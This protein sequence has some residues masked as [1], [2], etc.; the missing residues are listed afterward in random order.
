MLSRIAGAIR[1]SHVS[2]SERS[3][4]SRISAA[5]LAI[6][7]FTVGVKVVALGSTLLIA[8]FFGTGDDL[9]AFL[10]AFLLPSM[11]MSVI[12]GAFRSALIPTYVQVRE[13]YGSLHAQS[14]F[15]RIMFVAS[16]IL[17][18]SVGCFAV[19]VPY[20]LPLLASGF[21]PTKLAL[22]I[23]LSYLL[24]PV[25][26][27]KGIAT[28]YGA[29]LNAEERFSLVAAAPALIPATT[30]LF[31]LLWPVPATRIYGLAVATIVGMVGE[32]I[33]V[34][35]ALKLRGIALLPRRAASSAASRQVISQY[36]PIL[37][38]A[39][40]MS[41]TAFVDE[42]MAASLSAGSLASLSYGGRFVNVILQVLSGAIA[43]AV[44]PFFSKLVDERNWSALRSLLRVYIARILVVTAGITLLLVVSSETL[45]GLVL[46]RG[47]FG[48]G[49]TVLVG[50]IQAVYALQIPFYVCGIM[51][52]RV[53]SSLKAN[54]VLVIGS[55]ANLV[56]NICLN[57]LFMQIWGV[58]GVALSTVCVYLF[59]IAYIVI[60]VYRIL[61][62]GGGA[63]RLSDR[64][65]SG[66]SGVQDAGHRTAEAFGDALARGRGA[67]DSDVTR[68][69][70]ERSF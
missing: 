68:L 30:I 5:A 62:S 61:L 40:L 24:L 64:Q 17:L 48:H 32:L 46:Q 47:V 52:V 15:S 36:F 67:S 31:M 6:G 58:T 22:A 19:L 16:G 12:C 63:A 53:I 21:P 28:I 39:L 54:H 13:Q 14:L 7:G 4:G 27:V 42:A 34:S 29:A 35:W 43:T 37:A 44:L 45:I 20:L 11:G 2:S 3:V 59:S 55:F 1:G 38:G 10:I 60:M 8:S 69:G 57:Y 49:D 50:R 41:G 51:L 33:A 66:G 70:A 18:L 25:I 9:E 65:R 26:A 23:Q 56:I